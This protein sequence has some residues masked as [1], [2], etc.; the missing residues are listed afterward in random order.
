MLQWTLVLSFQSQVTAERLSLKL[1]SFWV[2]WTKRELDMGS[3]LILRHKSAAFWGDI[4]SS[5]LYPSLQQP[6]S[7]EGP[8]PQRRY[9]SAAVGDHGL[10]P[11]DML[12]Q[13]QLSWQLHSTGDS[14][15]SA[16]AAAR[17]CWWWIY[18][19]WQGLCDP[20]REKQMPLKYD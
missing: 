19:V 6:G 18:G 15:L 1:M 4:P 20:Q 5:P 14:E 10:S 17:K 7:V 2:D 12:W 16:N 8:L 13:Y 11:A 9:I 3:Y